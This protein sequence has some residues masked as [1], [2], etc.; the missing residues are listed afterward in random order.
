MEPNPVKYLLVRLTITQGQT[1]YISEVG[2]FDTQAAA[3]KFLADNQASYQDEGH[4]W[5][6]RTEY[7]IVKEE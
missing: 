2:R 5:S 7:E 6:G 3:E 4:A 1:D